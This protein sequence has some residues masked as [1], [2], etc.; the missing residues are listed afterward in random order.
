LQQFVQ[1]EQQWTITICKVE[2]LAQS[3]DLCVKARTP[4]LQRI[5][6]S[7]ARTNMQGRQSK[8]ARAGT[9]E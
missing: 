6:D 1:Q 5:I 2:K 7:D 3:R 4:F 8:V 9:Q